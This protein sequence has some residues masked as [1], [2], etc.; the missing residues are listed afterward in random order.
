MVAKGLKAAIGSPSEY[1][2][3][4]EAGNF[5]DDYDTKIPQQDDGELAEILDARL[6]GMS[7]DGSQEE[8]KTANNV[9]A[10]SN[11]YGGF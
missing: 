8:K 5:R 10:S 7:L 1:S 6:C 4:K 2:R 3:N 9:A 11:A